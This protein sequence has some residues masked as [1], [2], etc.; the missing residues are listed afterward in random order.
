[1]ISDLIYDVG[2][3]DGDDTEYY[4]AKGFRVVA[5]EANPQMVKRATQRFKQKVATG[6]VV[7]LPIGVSDPEGPLPFYISNTNPEWNTFDAA[8][9]KEKPTDFEQV[10]ISCRR[11]RSVLD[12]FGTPYYLKLDIEGNEIHCLKDLVRLDLPRYVSFEKTAQHSIESLILLRELG[13]TGFKLISQGNLLPVQ[14]P[15]TFEQ[16]RFERWRHVLTSKNLLLRV[17]RRA[18]VRRWINPIRYR[19]DWTFPLGS[20]GPFG[21]DTPG[22]WQTFDEIMAT[23]TKANAAFAAREP[24]VFWGAEGFSFWA[25]FHVK[26]T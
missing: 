5:I 9:I 23:V 26:L 6:K 3:Y 15:P 4:L 11:F 7:I 21:E 17:V 10:T 22:R 2:M 13:Y 14:Y 25:D 8:A 18:G 1:V 20:S 24:S 12:Q 16:Q 19:P